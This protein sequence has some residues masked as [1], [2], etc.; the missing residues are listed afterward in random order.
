MNSENGKRIYIC[1]SMLRTSPDSYPSRNELRTMC[2]NFLASWRK[3]TKCSKSLLTRDYMPPIDPNELWITWK[4]FEPL[5]LL[6]LR[7]YI[8]LAQ[9]CGS[10]RN[11]M[12]F[13]L[14]L[15]TEIGLDNDSSLLKVQIFRCSWEGLRHWAKKYRKNVVSQ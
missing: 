13:D 8:S 12:N 7:H 6:L 10:F 1:F 5:S 15:W 3:V 4:G 2:K 11:I 9:S 14:K